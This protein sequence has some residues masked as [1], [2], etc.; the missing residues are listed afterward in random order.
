MNEY[1][2]IYMDMPVAAKGFVIKT[3][4][5]GEDYYTVVLNPKYNWEQN[6]KTYKHELEHIECGDLDGH[7]DPNSI[8]RLRHY[9]GNY[10]N[11]ISI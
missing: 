10:G 6:Q 8:E 7:G 4:D 1:R 5:N 3:F 11:Q 2:T 9:E